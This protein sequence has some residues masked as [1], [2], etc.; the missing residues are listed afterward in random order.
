MKRRDPGLARALAGVLCGVKLFGQL[1]DFVECLGS[2]I[3]VAVVERASQDSD[4]DGHHAANTHL[5]I[6][7]LLVAEGYHSV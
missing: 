4:R 3:A 2:Q 1:G 6:F 5:L 7:E